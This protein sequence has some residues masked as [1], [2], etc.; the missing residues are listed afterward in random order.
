VFYHTSPPSPNRSKSPTLDQPHRLQL[1]DASTFGQD[2]RV[3]QAARLS[4]DERG[5]EPVANILDS[6]CICI[7]LIVVGTRRSNRVEK[8]RLVIVL[9]LIEK[10]LGML[11]IPFT[12]SECGA[13]PMHE[14][15]FSFASDNQHWAGET[16]CNAFESIACELGTGILQVF[17]PKDFQA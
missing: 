16:L 7:S 1:S 10:S 8:Q 4:G 13:C 6:R 12:R 5:F 2:A 3:L 9:D 11:M 14:G 17:S 15:H